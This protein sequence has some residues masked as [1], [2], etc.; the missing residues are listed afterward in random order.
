MW[1][2]CGNMRRA[3]GLLFV[4]TGWIAACS[5]APAPPARRVDSAG[6]AEASARQQAIDAAA[7]Q[8]RDAVRIQLRPKVTDVVGAPAG[9]A[10]TSAEAMEVA[11]IELTPAAKGYE[12]RVLFTRPIR[13]PFAGGTLGC[14]LVATPDAVPVAASP[15]PGTTVSV[16]AAVRSC[17]V[18]EPRPVKFHVADRFLAAD[19][20][21]FSPIGG[22]FFELRNLSS[23]PLTISSAS[24]NYFD[25]TASRAKISLEIPPHTSMTLTISSAFLKQL[26]LPLSEAS[27]ISAYTFGL[28]VT[29]VTAGEVGTLSG[30]DQ[31][32][33]VAEDPYDRR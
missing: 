1:R 28:S 20:R 17:A 23:K 22:A 6:A 21:S 16:S 5:H 26:D 29:Y 10:F 13:R 25:A 7:L 32:P 8:R 9:E 18:S 31:V 27:A 33:V 11:R 19:L 15:D 14:T 24:V 30:N 12:A 4:A 3:L 2:S